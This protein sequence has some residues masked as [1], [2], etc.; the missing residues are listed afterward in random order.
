MAA[1]Y[2]TTSSAPYPAQGYPG[3]QYPSQ[4]YPVS[5]QPYPPPYSDPSSQSGYGQPIPQAP[6]PAYGVEQSN[7]TSSTVA[8][9]TVHEESNVK[10]TDNM[11]SFDDKSVRLGK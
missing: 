6:P 8:V 11:F 4:P 2:G 3:Q 7:M 1:P 5:N 9:V 10:G